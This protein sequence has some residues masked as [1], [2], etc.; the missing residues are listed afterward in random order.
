MLKYNGK[1]KETSAEILISI[2]VKRV[3]QKS[4]TVIALL[5]TGTS[6]PLIDKSLIEN[7]TFETKK[8]KETILKHKPESLR[9]REIP[10]LKA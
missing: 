7:S 5:D 2:S 10:G 3:S 1:E 9:P 6:K 8:G 4:V